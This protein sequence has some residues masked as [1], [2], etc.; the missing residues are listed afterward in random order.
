MWT[1]PESQVQAR[2]DSLQDPIIHG[3]APTYFADDRLK[4]AFHGAD[5]DTD[6]DID[7]P[8]TA[9]QS[10]VRHTLFPREDPREEIDVSGKS[11]SVSVSVPRCRCRRRGMPAL[12]IWQ[13]TP[14]VRWYT[15]SLSV[16]RTKTIT[17]Q[18]VSRSQVQPFG[19]VYQPVKHR[20][21][22]RFF[23]FFIRVTFFTFFNV[24]FIFPT[25][26]KIKKTLKIWYEH[27]HSYWPREVYFSHLVPIVATNT[28]TE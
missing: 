20:C 26:S 11:A 21:K 4:L 6:T 7:S 12:A 24:F 15:G 10:Y 3:L 25:F 14:A 22:K 1:L 18:A 23:T 19:T 16:P 2:S 5:T 13:G 8:N 28:V 27:F 17:G 9:I